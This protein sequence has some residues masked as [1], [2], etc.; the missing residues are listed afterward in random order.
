MWDTSWGKIATFAGFFTN[1]GPGAGMADPDAAELFHAILEQNEINTVFQPVISLTDGT[2]IGYEALSRGPQ[3]S[4]LER[5]SVLFETAQRLNKL[6]ELE[7]LCRT[8]ALEQA[9]YMPPDKMLFLNVDPKIIHD[10]RFQ[11]GLTTDLLDKYQLDPTG[12]IFEITEKTSVEDYRSFRRVLDH[13]TGQGYK[14][15]I[16]DT[17]SGYSGLRMLAETRPQFIKMDM[18]LVRD[19]DKDHLKQALIKAFYDFAILTN[20]KII[21]EGIETVSELYTLIDI[22]IHYGQGFLL[23]KPMPQFL[24][25]RPD[26]RELIQ[27]KNKQKKKETFYTAI[28]MPVGEIARCDPPHNPDCSGAQAIEAFNHNLSLRGI[29]VVEDGRPVGLLMKDRFLANLATQYGVAIYMNRPIRLLMDR[30]PLVVD[31]HTSL[32]Q[33]AKLVVARTDDTLYDY[34]IV[35][36][37]ES[38]YGVTSVRRLLEKTTQLEITRAKHC[39]PLSGLPGNII[40]EDK[41]NRALDGKSDFSILYFDLD[42]FKPYNDTYG[43]EHGD[44]ILCLTAEVIRQ[45]LTLLGPPD[46]FIGHIGGDDFI[47]V[48][49]S[50]NVDQLCQAVIDNFDLRI[51]GFYTEEHLTNGFI[52]AKNRHGREERYPIM[53]ISIAVVTS[54]GRKFT[55]ATQLAEAAGEVKKQCKLTW[56]SCYK[57]AE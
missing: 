34:I 2:V 5:P 24:D 43:F 8:A 13:Y 23:Q 41:I 12:I 57:V 22:G 47:A 21:A 44:K 42:N 53:A 3:G 39:N 33:V 15:A 40:I 32:E 10:V 31:Y 9:K 16:D 45:Q 35:T 52:I 20:M 14:I 49:H 56:H 36:K 1:I 28:T 48:V 26:I 25:L 11:K 46:S 50:A 17:G 7:L 4:A 29:P 51:R 18:Q 6:W 37:N 30:D 19:I 38:Y 27:R 55:N 54:K